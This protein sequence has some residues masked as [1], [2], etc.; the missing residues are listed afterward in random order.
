MTTPGPTGPRSTAPPRPGAPPL[1]P[2]R[3]SPVFVIGAVGALIATVGLALLDGTIKSTDAATI[4]GQV[5]A[6]VVIAVVL[7]LIVFLIARLMGKARTT[8]GKVQIAFWTTGVLAVSQCATLVTRGVGGRNL[9][10][11]AVTD[12]ERAGLVIDST[13]IRHSGFG[14]SLP[15]PGPD[16]QPD[17]TLQRTM[18]SALAQEKEL[19]AWVLRSP[20]SGATLIVQVTKGV[21]EAEANFRAFVRG[22]RR[23]AGDGTEVLLDSTTWAG[24]TREYRRTA[25]SPAGVYVQIRCVPHTTGDLGL[26]VCITTGSGDAHDLDYVREGLAFAG[27]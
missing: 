10:L 1:A 11:T 4:L 21:R 13:G 14:F 15:N 19:A 6:V 25:R 22:V 17:S 18:D 27:P 3:T 26:I 12:S 24:P 20:N 8:S 9:F 5:A 23:T 16:F 2:A 7:W